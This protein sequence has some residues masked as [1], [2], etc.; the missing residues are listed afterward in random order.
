MLFSKLF[1]CVRY[2]LERYYNIPIYSYVRCQILLVFFFFFNE[3]FNF[4]NVIKYIN[5]AFD[6][7]PICIVPVNGKTK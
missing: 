2:T 5:T 6:V 7:S 3:F 4:W 1:M